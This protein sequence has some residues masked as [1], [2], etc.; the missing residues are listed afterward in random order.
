MLQKLF[1]LKSVTIT[2]SSEDGIYVTTEQPLIA[3]MHRLKGR[4]TLDDFFVFDQIKPAQP[5]KNSSEEII[6]RR[7]TE[8]DL[9]EIQ[10]G[11]LESFLP[12][13]PDGTL[14]LVFKN[15]G[16]SRPMLFL[17]KR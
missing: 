6:V 3:G 12:T 9:I 5:E 8:Q 15:L 2:G 1:N 11:K 4:K 14:K 17:L 10:E 7:L 13:E 16:S